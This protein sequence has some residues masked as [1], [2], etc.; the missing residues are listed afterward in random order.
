M[1][2]WR[3]L[4]FAAPGR[5]YDAE[6]SQPTYLNQTAWMPV[7][8]DLPDIENRDCY[9]KLVLFSGYAGAWRGPKTG[10]GWMWFDPGSGFISDGPAPQRL[11]LIIVL[12][13]D[14]LMVLIGIKLASATDPPYRREITMLRRGVLCNGKARLK[15]STAQLLLPL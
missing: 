7:W 9:C 3:H 2:H 13:D 12:D 14:P 11:H 1:L 5:H 8:P 6:V 4:D 10:S 15:H